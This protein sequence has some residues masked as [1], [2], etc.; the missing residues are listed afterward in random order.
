VREISA[1]MVLACSWAF[2]LRV[3]AQRNENHLNPEQA[4]ASLPAQIQVIRQSFCH[5]DDESFAANLKLRL[6]LTN[7][8][9][10]VAIL[11]R[12]IEPPTIVRVALTAE[13]GKNGNFVYSPDVHSTVAELPKGPRFGA[14]PNAKLFILL[15]PG[16]KFET[17][18]PVAVFGASETGT[19]KSGNGLLAKGSYVLQVGVH[20]WPYEWPYFSVE[21]SAQDIRQRWMKY[22]DLA[23]GTVYSNFAPFTLP[24]HFDNPRCP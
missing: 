4:S 11:S 8:S 24:E 12:K 22:G 13:A 15:S 19:V 14:T 6:M 18:V 5:L 3:G 10:H 7:N 2:C 23:V 1:L 9:E 17:E 16:E 21:T 20:T